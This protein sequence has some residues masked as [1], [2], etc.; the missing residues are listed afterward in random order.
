MTIVIHTRNVFINQVL[1]AQE[2]MQRVQKQQKSTTK[3]ENS[4]KR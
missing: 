2:G 4:R 1:N 3:V